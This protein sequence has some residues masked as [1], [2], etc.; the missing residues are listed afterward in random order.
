MKRYKNHNNVDHY[1][2]GTEEFILPS[3]T[4]PD[5]ALPLKTL[6]ERHTRSMYVP[7]HQTHYDPP[8]VDVPDFGKMSIEERDEFL[9]TSINEVERI[10]KEGTEKL[11]Q[12][13]AEINAKLKA[14]N[15]PPEAP[16]T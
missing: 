10:K 5:Q 6:L 2:S 8:G 4:V 11:T 7:T 3:L 9:Q 12:K 1:K 16:K 15:A 14:Q 13:R